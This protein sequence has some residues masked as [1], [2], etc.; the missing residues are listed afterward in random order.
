MQWALQ[1]KLHLC[2]NL[3]SIWLTRSWASLICG[4]SCGVNLTL[5]SSHGFI[6]PWRMQSKLQYLLRYLALV[7]PRLSAETLKAIAANNTVAAR[8]AGIN[9]YSAFLVGITTLANIKPA[10]NDIKIKKVSWPICSACTKSRPETKE[11]SP[12]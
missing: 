9:R 11:L 6:Q 8:E 5:S 10:I 2:F 7:I 3:S 12:I 4:L 1:K